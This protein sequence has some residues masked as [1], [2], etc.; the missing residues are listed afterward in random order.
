VASILIFACF[1]DKMLL[2]DVMENINTDLE[3][4][5]NANSGMSVEEVKSVIFASCIMNGLSGQAMSGAGG[6]L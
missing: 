4:S 1:V 2:M 5:L 3:Q 6:P